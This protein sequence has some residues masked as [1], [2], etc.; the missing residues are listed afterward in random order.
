MLKSTK[1]RGSF[2]VVELIIVVV[3]V[4]ILVTLAMPAYISARRRAKDREARAL[5]KLIQVAEKTYRLE[6]SRYIACADNASCNSI[7]RLDLPPD[8]SSGGSWDYAV[9]SVDNTATPPEFNATA[10][11]TEGT[12]NWQIDE[13]DVEAN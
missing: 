13:D 4:A 5:L 10:T 12:Q 8:T 7:L 9:G 6:T 2:S 3:V 1:N 11:G